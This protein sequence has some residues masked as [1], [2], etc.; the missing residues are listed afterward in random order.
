MSINNLES[1]NNALKFELSSKSIEEEKL[2][3]DLIA[4]TESIE[5]LKVMSYEQEK[6]I[7]L[8][9]CELDAAMQERSCEVDAQQTEFQRSK[10]T[11]QLKDEEIYLLNDQILKLSKSLDAER[12][13]IQL[14]TNELNELKLFYKN[15][16]EK[17]ATY[18]QQLEADNVEIKKR[19]VKLIK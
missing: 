17:N 16:N 9:K 2:K 4:Q 3:K 1:D 19:L 6:T 10:I 12:E 8:L 5:S 11:L 18:I 13:Q 7:K 15:L 14:L